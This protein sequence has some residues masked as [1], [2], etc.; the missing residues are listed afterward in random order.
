[1]EIS[2]F[3]I[4]PSATRR[5]SRPEIEKIIVAAM[6]QVLRQG[7]RCIIYN[8]GG[9]DE[10]RSEGDFPDDETR[11]EAWELKETRSCVKAHAL[12]SPPKD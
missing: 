7:D 2:R 10:R 8:N 12:H 3:V 4:K 9:G 5:K 11:E 1:M 6:G